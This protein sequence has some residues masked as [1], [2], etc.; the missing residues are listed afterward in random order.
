MRS[1]QVEYGNFNEIGALEY[2]TILET[3]KKFLGLKRSFE[4]CTLHQGRI[5]DKIHLC[6]S[7]LTEIHE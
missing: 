2:K 6:I 1:K 3:L 7:T 4:I 5:S